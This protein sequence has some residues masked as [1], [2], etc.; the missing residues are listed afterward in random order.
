MGRLVGLKY[1]FSEEAFSEEK[2]DASDI[3]RARGFA[4]ESSLPGDDEALLNKQ[5]G[6]AQRIQQRFEG[7][8]LRRATDS[9]D[10]EGNRLIT[11]PPYQEIPVIVKPT[12]R[13]MDIITELADRIKER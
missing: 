4:A 13:E 3:R 7:H 8:I 5:R 9:L 6:I 10:W 1:F 2:T 11:L 12:Q